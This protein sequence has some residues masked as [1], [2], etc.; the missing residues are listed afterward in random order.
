[1]SIIELLER[2]K[3]A[4]FPVAEVPEDRPTRGSLRIDEMDEELVRALHA[5]NVDHLSPEPRKF[6]N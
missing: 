4:V 1:M 3:H 5:A 6:T 2:V